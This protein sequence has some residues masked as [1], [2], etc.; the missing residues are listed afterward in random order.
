MVRRVFGSAREAAGKLS[1]VWPLAQPAALFEAASSG[2]QSAKSPASKSSGTKATSL[3]HLPHYSRSLLKIRIPVSVHLASKKA[4]ELS[5]LLRQQRS[6]LQ[7]TKVWI[8][9][10]VC[11]TDARLQIRLPAHDQVGVY[12]VEQ[13]VTMLQAPPRD[14]RHRVTAGDSKRIAK[15]LVKVG[16]ARSDAQ[17][18]VGPYVLDRKAID[19]GRTWTDYLARH[20]E[21]PEHVRIRHGGPCNGCDTGDGGA[22][23]AE[24]HE[25]S[26]RD[27]WQ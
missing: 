6:Q 22:G 26:G 18:K 19:S 25:A 7:D 2:G 1:L 11:F 4:R 15:A 10:A 12:A 24:R 21:L 5:G 23:K 8:A 16:I 27:D 17:Y 9:E 3:G 14:E 20:T 13:L